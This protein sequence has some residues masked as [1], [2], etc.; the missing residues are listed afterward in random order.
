MHRERK[1]HGKGTCTIY[2][3]EEGRKAGRTQDW[4]NC[5]VR[6]YEKEIQH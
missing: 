1:K 5:S 2:S 4:G 6:L 3:R